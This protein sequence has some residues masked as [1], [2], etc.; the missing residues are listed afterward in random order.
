MNSRDKI[1]ELLTDYRSYKFAVSNCESNPDELQYGVRVQ[2]Y[3]NSNRVITINELDYL[4][5]SRIIM[6]LEEAT[7]EVLSDEERE[8]IRYKYL[9]RNPLTLKII[10]KRM[11]M[12]ENTATH[13]HRRALKKLAKALMFV[14]IPE[15][16]N[17]DHVLTTA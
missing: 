9:E 4:R 8:V 17:L 14:E 12:H 10:S 1:V 3:L 5:Y 7:K 13:I 16:H 6:T 2:P 15:I 11:G